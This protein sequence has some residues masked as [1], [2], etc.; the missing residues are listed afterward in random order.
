M[1]HKKIKQTVVEVRPQPKQEMFLASPADICIFGGGLGA[2]S[3]SFAIL[4]DALR[5]VDNPHFGCVM[6]RRTSPMQY[7]FTSDCGVYEISIPTRSA[8]LFKS[9]PEF[10]ANL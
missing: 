9:T 8:N 6:F 2:V 7:M 3:K 10:S 4:V 1:S 5:H